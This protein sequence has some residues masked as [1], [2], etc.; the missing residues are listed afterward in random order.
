MIAKCYG[1]NISR[2]RKL[3]EK[4]KEGKKHM[5]AISSAEMPQEAFMSVLETNPS[6]S[7]EARALN[8][9]VWATTY[10]GLGANLGDRA[11]SITQACGKLDALPT[12][13]VVK[14]SSLYETDPVGVTAQPKF[15]NAVAELRTI[16]SAPALLAQLLQLEQQM[17]R[18]RTVR[19]GPRTIDM[20]ILLYNNEAIN[21]PGLTVPHPRLAERA[22]VL[23]PLAEIAPLLVLPGETQTLQKKAAA[24]PEKGNIHCVGDV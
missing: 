9:K 5:K 2:K 12:I 13:Q 6:L 23:V 15:L 16:L 10:I 14:V 8:P 22:F 11:Q 20:D 4:Q 1:G 17:G 24:L 21:C 3:L 19:W 7:Q 18:V